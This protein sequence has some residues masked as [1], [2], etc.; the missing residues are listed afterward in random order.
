[1][2]PSARTMIGDIAIKADVDQPSKTYRIDYGKNQIAGYV[3]GAEAVA[4]AIYKILL[5]ERFKH[6]IYSWNYGIEVE[7]LIGKSYSVYESELQRIVKEAVLQDKRINNI[8]NFMMTQSGR[9]SVSIA[10]A[11]ETIFGDIPIETEVERNV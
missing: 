8:S 6:L 3:D 4:Q 9:N 5:T 2:I 11:A 10:F 7:T 1:M